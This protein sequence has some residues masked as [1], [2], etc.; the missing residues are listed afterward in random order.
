MTRRQSGGVAGRLLSW[1]RPASSP[2]RLSLRPSV[3][4]VS[5]R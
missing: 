2:F 1:W 5:R 3:S 4:G